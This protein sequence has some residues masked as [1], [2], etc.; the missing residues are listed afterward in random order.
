MTIDGMDEVQRQLQANAEAAGGRWSLVG[1]VGEAIGHLQ[2][3]LP[4]GRVLVLADNRT[5]ALAAEAVRTGLDADMVLVPHRNAGTVVAGQVEADALLDRAKGAAAVL[6]V[7]A[8]TLNDLAK[9][10]A[11]QLGCTAAVVATA[12]SMNGYSSSTAALL[13]DGVKVTTPCAPP[14]VIVAP[15][16]L[17][18]SAPARMTA[19]GYADLHSRPVSLSDWAL[20]HRL[21]DVPWDDS[22]LDLVHASADLASASLDGLTDRQPESVAR[23]FAALL[24]SGRAMDVAGSSAPS[25]GAEHLISHLLDMRH[26]AE[27]GP[28][29]LHGCQVGVATRAV[30]LLYERLLER[31][32]ARLSAANL[33]PWSFTADT[34]KREFGALWP[35]VEPVARKVHGSADERHARIE[36]LQQESSTLWPHLRRLLGPDPSSADPLSE[37]GAPTRFRD[38]GVDRETARQSLRLARYVRARYTI[39]DLAAD[40]GCLDEWIDDIL[41]EVA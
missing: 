9:I 36:R 31:D 37:A 10:T 2:Q 21:L 17:L 32:G 23:L 28:H 19:A 24:L 12:A 29:D 35:A 39:L 41:D 20:S 38:L 25:S 18:C 6:A 34:L 1:D 22:A 15:L 13:Q 4:D 11:H 27:G 33:P 40:I 14:G 8:G 30:A 26:F 5:A 7:G 16:D 3:Q